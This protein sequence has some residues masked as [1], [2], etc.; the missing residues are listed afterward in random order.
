MTLK[1][2]FDLLRVLDLTSSHMTDFQHKPHG[3]FTVVG[4][5]KS[6]SKK[7]FEKD[8]MLHRFIPHCRQRKKMEKLR[9]Y[10]LFYWRSV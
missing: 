7:C 2:P 8:A 4:V 10:G 6:T 3:S 9:L 5:T 1:I